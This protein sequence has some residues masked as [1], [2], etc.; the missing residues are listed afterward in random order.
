MSGWTGT[1]NVCYF[2]AWPNA[3][4]TVNCSAANMNVYVLRP[5]LSIYGFKWSS[6]LFNRVLLDTKKYRLNIALFSY[7]L[8]NTARY[9]KCCWFA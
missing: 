9:G 8:L 2:W 7:V 5:E 6:K 1:E 3:N 4:K